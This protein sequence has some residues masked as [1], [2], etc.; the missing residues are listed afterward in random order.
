VKIL[1]KL[2]NII[3]Y[4]FQKEN[5][6][7][8]SLI[9]VL[10][11]LDSYSKN[12]IIENYNENLIFVNDY[13]NFNLIWNNGVGFGFLSTESKVIYY[14]VTTLIAIIILGL[15]YI[16]LI[17]KKLEKL[18]YCLII[19]GAIG[20]F[21]DRLVYNAVPDF[22]DFHYKNFHWFTFNVADIIISI[23]IILFILQNF[24]YKTEI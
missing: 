22:I 2:K 23:G 17:S 6:Y 16:F 18:I 8:F 5:I 13:I 19:G 7:F 3:H 11:F 10:F 4:L 14:S 15:I 21:Y 12:F 20:N 9:L 1:N 24:F